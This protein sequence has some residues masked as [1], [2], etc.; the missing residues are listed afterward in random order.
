VK[1]G[2]CKNKDRE[3]NR[4]V[5]KEVSDLW[6]IPTPEDKCFSGVFSSD[7]FA[8]ALQQLTPGKAPRS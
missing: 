7:E 1:N 3:S 6:R 8:L 5:N 4:L 2:T